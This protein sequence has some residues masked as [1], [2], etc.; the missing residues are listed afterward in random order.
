MR[1]GWSYDTVVVAFHADGS[2]DLTGPR[3]HGDEDPSLGARRLDTIGQHL[4]GL[5]LQCSIKG[6]DEGTALGRRVQVVL[7]SRDRGPS[8]TDLH[9]L[10]AGRSG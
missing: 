3:P 2:Q 10:L 6:Q 5:E 9:D 4:L 7:A 8:G 1:S